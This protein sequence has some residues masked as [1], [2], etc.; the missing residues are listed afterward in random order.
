MLVLDCVSVSAVSRVSCQSSKQCFGL[1]SSRPLPDDG[2]SY[3]APRNN[4]ILKNKSQNFKLT[5][6]HSRLLLSLHMTAGYWA[7]WV[8]VQTEGSL[9]SQFLQVQTHSSLITI[10]FLIFASG[11]TCS[12][13]PISFSETL[14]SAPLW[15]NPAPLCTLAQ[16]SRL[17]P[18]NESPVTWWDCKLVRKLETRWPLAIVFNCLKLKRKGQLTARRPCRHSQ[19]LLTYL[20]QNGTTAWIIGAVGSRHSH[21]ASLSHLFPLSSF[22]SRFP[23]QWSFTQSNWNV[24]QPKEEIVGSEGM[25][26]LFFCL[27]QFDKKTCYLLV[28]LVL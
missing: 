28:V 17:G 5:S 22:S 1:I 8:H 14:R 4:K 10:A 6:L 21:Y 23:S 7:T 2:K 19:Y 12:K 24:T 11:Q 26:R 25:D 18:G 27:L 16:A 9:Q 15:G 20:S 13:G 3:F